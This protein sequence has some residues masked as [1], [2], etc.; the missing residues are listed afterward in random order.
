MTVIKIVPMPG[1]QGPQGEPGTGGGGDIA[2]FVFTYNSEEENSTMAIA[3]HDM[4]IKTTRTGSQDADIDIDSADD[5]WITANDEIDISSISDNVKIYTNDF[6]T[7]WEFHADG[8]IHFPDDTVQTTA[9]T[10]GSGGDL[11]VPV[12]IKDSEDDDF[13]TFTK[14]DTGTARIASPQDDLSLRS[15]RDITLFAGSDAGPG[16]V[17][18]GWGDSQ[19][20]PDAPNRVAT[21]ADIQNANT[22]DITFVENTISSD[23]GDDIVI[24]NKN[25]DGI[26]KARITLDQSDEQVLI[27][28]I[29]SDNDWFND[30]QWSTAVW[31]GSVVTITNTP[32]II[33]FFNNALGNITRVSINDGGLLTYE[34]AS[35]GSGDMTL[36]VGGTPPEGQDPLTVTEIRF[37]SELVSEIN[38]DNDDSEF[39]IISRGMSMTIDSS[40]DLELKA[41]DEDLHLYANDDVRFTTN[42]D[43]NGTEHSWRM[44][45]I[46]RFELPGA[47][48]IQNPVNSSGDGGNYDTIKIVPD[49]DLVEQ[50]YHEDQYLIIDPTGPNHIHIRAGGVIDEST[51]DLILG[52]ER[53][54]IK[55]SDTNG[56]TVVQSKQEDYN[57]TYENI[58]GDGG[59]VYSVGTAMAEPDINDFMIIDGAKYVI[60]NVTRDEQNGVTSYETTPSFNFVY[61]ES[62]TFTRDNGNYAWEFVSVDER[63][64]LILPSEQPMIINSAVPGDITLSAYNGVKLSFADT[65]GAGLEFPDDSIQTTAF[66][67]GATGSFVSQ[68]GKTITVTNGI[69]TGIEVIP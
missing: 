64:A 16:N 23:T 41:R 34:G 6:N 45:E 54:G 50:Q 37:Y 33:N 63:P 36:N 17:F 57:W 11:V 68:D 52:G 4:V 9:Y 10:G 25:D 51:A 30:T 8:G 20:D 67:G 2:D 65:E 46:G 15:A 62:Y 49:S 31:S 29:A 35:F 56:T 28:A 13:I 5:V 47:G 59:S 39:N 22:G 43:N 24:E 44:S 14:T 61:N 60:T 48:Y 53:A 69:I 66:V 32:D 18:I 19:Q 38:I 12:T 40:G 27:E 42:W 26:V 55:V 7:K 58:N 1:P 3:N 21:L